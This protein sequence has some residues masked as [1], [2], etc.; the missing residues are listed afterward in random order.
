MK[1]II[2][3]IA[4]LCSF[5]FCDKIVKVYNKS[6]G[7]VVAVYNAKQC[8]HSMLIETNSITY[9]I[10]H[11]GAT[12]V[13]N[14]SKWKT[15]FHDFII[16]CDKKSKNHDTFGSYNNSLFTYSIEKVNMSLK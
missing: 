8:S 3:L 5:G 7:N 13:T 1:K 15:N 4:I 9:E 12:Y 16:S 11:D 14:D 10:Q 2:I 6:T